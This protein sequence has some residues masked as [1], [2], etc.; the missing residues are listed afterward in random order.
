MNWLIHI[1]QSKPMALPFERPQFRFRAGL[2]T[3]D[4]SMTDETAARERQKYEEELEYGGSGFYG[5]IGKFQRMG[6]LVVKYTNDAHNDVRIAE[7]FM[8]NPAPCIVPIHDVDL[9]QED[10]PLWSI[11][12]DEV[13]TLNERQQYIIHHMGERFGQHVYEI[14]GIRDSQVENIKEYYGVDGYIIDD[15]INMCKCILEHGFSGRDAHEGNVGYTEDRT[16]V[17]FDL[18][19]LRKYS[20]NKWPFKFSQVESIVAAAI[21]INDK[22]Y[23]GNNHAEASVKAFEDIHDVTLPKIA[24][25][26]QLTP[27]QQAGVNL[28]LWDQ[29]SDWV[30]GVFRSGNLDGF[31]TD[32]GRFV[33]RVEA[34]QIAQKSHQLHNEPEAQE[35]DWLDSS[36]LVR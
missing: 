15:Y 20:E 14:A 10:P 29:F 27:A 34:K 6:D 4:R 13:M 7:H 25:F 36:E 8:Q 21:F 5:T 18:G 33:N 35:S 16:M 1:S 2:E 3:I 22:I 11:V 19:G 30:G 17:L 32:T 12:M 24:E 23:L 28:D 9:I 26:A 31:Y